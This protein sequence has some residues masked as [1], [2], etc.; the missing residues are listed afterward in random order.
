VMKTSTGVRPRCVRLEKSRLG[1]GKP[2][3]AKIT[4]DGKSSDLG[5]FATREEAE[6]ACRA[7]RRVFPAKVKS[8]PPVSETI[9]EAIR[10]ELAMEKSRRQV[11]RL[12]KVSHETLRQIALKAL[13]NTVLGKDPREPVGDAGSFISSAAK[14]ISLDQSEVVP[15]SRLFPFGYAPVRLDCP[16]G[17][18]L[19]R[20]ARPS[21]AA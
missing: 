10:S 2:Y 12:F 18:R 5:R 4:V 3:R 17:P 9:Q 14:S 20:G 8:A 15:W 19:P 7:V 13:G 11:A 16:G 1:R 6:A 21:L